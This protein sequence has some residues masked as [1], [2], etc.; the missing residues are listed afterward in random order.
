M[1]KTASSSPIGLDEATFAV[2]A[3][4]ML[5]K[6]DRSYLESLDVKEFGLLFVIAPIIRIAVLEIGELADNLE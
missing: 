2:M 4:E 1:R 5:E 6:V 3:P